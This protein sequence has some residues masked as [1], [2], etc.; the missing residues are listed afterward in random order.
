MKIKTDTESWKVLLFV[1]Q[2]DGTHSIGSASRALGFTAGSRTLEQIVWRLR[3]IGLLSAA[4]VRRKIH[5]TPSGK[6]HL[7]L[8]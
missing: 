5:I 6:K 3:K 2:N 8:E 7:R 4:D 1:C